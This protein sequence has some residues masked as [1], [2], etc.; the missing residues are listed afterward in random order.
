MLRSHRQISQTCFFFTSKVLV[1]DKENG[2]VF[3]VVD[4]R[5]AITA[6]RLAGGNQQGASVMQD[7]LTGGKK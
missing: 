3:T 5:A 1:Q 6:K 2:R 4:N 7:L